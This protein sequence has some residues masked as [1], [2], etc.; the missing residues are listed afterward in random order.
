MWRRANKIIPGGTMLFSK[1]RF[2]LPKFWPAYFNKSK[3][4]YLWDLD[5]YKY[6]DFSLMGVGTNL[7]GYSNTKSIIK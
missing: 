1:N 7:L 5:N 4:C 2:I 6:L 3:G